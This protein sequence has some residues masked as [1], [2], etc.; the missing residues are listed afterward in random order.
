VSRLVTAVQ[1]VLIGE[2]RRP[3][4]SGSPP[5]FNEGLILLICK[6]RQA[7]A[8]LGDLEEQFH[9]DCKTVGVKHANFRHLMQTLSS[10]A[11]LL[12]HKL[13]WGWLIAAWEA[14]RRYF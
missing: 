6:K 7:R 2:V 12:W 10:I 13:R 3:L 4:P 5:R 11:P 9:D 1:F 8:I 14:G